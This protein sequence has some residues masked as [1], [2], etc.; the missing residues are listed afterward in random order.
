MAANIFR[1][2]LEI[3]SKF[4]PPS[5]SVTDGL[6]RCE[7]LQQNMS[8]CRHRRNTSCTK[9]RLANSNS[10]ICRYRIKFVTTEIPCGNRGHPKAVKSVRT[11][12][13][14]HSFN[15]CRLT[16]SSVSALSIV[17]GSVLLKRK[18]LVQN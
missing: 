2:I 6:L 4:Q 5:L 18:L 16:Q 17:S 10:C 8:S 11:S 1:C 7:S 13:D 15:K 12:A 9:A 3:S 14:L